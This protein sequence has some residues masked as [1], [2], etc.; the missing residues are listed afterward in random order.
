[1]TEKDFLTGE[2]SSICIIVS[3]VHQKL[4]ISRKI[5]E[6]DINQ[7]GFIVIERKYMGPLEM[8]LTA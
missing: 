7:I 5:Y 2:Y 3:H 4:G 8:S 1:M 6:V